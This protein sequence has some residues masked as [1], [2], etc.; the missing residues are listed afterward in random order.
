M[1]NVL[2]LPL[3]IAAIAQPS[4]Q[5]SSLTLPQAQVLAQAQQA[6]PAE[7]PAV[8][9]LTVLSYNVHGLPWPF[10]GRRRAQIRDIGRE[11]AALRTEGRAPD[12]VLIQ[13]NF[14]DPDEL[15]S[16]SGYKHWA[17]GPDK[18]LRPSGPR[19]RGYGAKVFFSGEGWGKVT[20]SGLYVL[21]DFPIMEVEL[22]AYRYCAGWDCLANKGVM[23]VHLDV[24]GLPGGL[25]VV[26]TH[27]NAD[28]HAA[29]VSGP[30]SLKAHN[31][32]TEELNAFVARARTPGAALL[33]GGDFNVKNDEARYGYQASIRPFTVVSEFCKV[34]AE[35][36]SGPAMDQPRPWLASQDLQAF[37]A[38]GPVTIRPL[39]ASTIFDGATYKRLSDHDG[40]LVRYRLGWGSSPE[41]TTVS[42]AN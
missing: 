24:P 33:V 14:D 19:V 26:N 16:L 8:R 40:Y 5:K 32:Q 13:E 17:A 18:R 1:A 38:A 21:S 29:K 39:G 41:Q 23:M 35:C 20:S 37:A 3:I 25:D 28:R 7:R 6:E 10:A 36:R 9:E 42:A 27:M 12:V 11:L 2:A 31:L 34:E 30:R 15:V 22:D 4:L